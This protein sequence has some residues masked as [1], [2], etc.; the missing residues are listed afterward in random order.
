MKRVYGKPESCTSRPL[1][2]WPF[3]AAALLMQSSVVN[4]FGIEFGNKQA[5]DDIEF[6]P[7]DGC[8][9]KC[10]S[11]TRSVRGSKTNAE[12]RRFPLPKS[13]VFWACRRRAAHYR[14]LTC[15]T[16]HKRTTLPSVRFIPPCSVKRKSIV[17]FSLIKSLE[18]LF[19]PF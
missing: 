13:L 10:L 7:V 6:V 14:T 3:C 12:E 2:C 15:G 17:D 4:Y 16:I 9:V 11:L 19:R 1:R 5:T 8:T 18:P